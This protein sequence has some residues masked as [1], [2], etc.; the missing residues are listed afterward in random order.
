MNASEKALRAVKGRISSLQSFGTVDGPG[1]RYVVFMQGCSLRCACCHNPETWALDGGEERTVGEIFDMILRYRSYFGRDGGVT[2]SGG[3]PLLQDEFVFALFTLCRQ[4]SIH[5]CLDTSGCVIGK[6][7]EKVL[8]VTDLVLLDLKYATEEKYRRYVGCALDTPL[9]FLR[10]LTLRNIPVWIRQVI[11][12]G[13]NDSRDDLL[14][15]KNLLAQA[16]NV[17][18]IELL[19]F[20]RLCLEKY[21]S[22][23][24]E[25]PF[26]DIPDTTDEE[27][28]RAYAILEENQIT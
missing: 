14:Q 22:M 3:E 15:T 25:F 5:T 27:I 26:G 17:Q 19:P 28:A 6:K 21:R 9:S 1:V 10:I 4:A 20:R 16:P 2:I 24:I 13:V 12:R 18:K 23:Q 11:V 7:A 8:S